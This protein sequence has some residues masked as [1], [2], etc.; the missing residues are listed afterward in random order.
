MHIFKCDI[1]WYFYFTLRLY[2]FT[3]TMTS[4][5]YLLPHLSFIQVSK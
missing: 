4:P 2:L 5:I 1:K 3:I